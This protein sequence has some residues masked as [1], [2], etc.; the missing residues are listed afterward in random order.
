MNWNNL[1]HIFSPCFPPS[2][3]NRGTKTDTNWW[4]VVGLKLYDTE[5]R[6]LVTLSYVQGELGEDAGG[7]R[8][9]DQTQEQTLE[10][11]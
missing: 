1:I 9:M 8:K 4:W 11:T 7:E 5:L 3:L 2:Y 10:I 6:L